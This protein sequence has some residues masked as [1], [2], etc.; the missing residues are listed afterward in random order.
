[1]KQIDITLLF[2]DNGSPVPKTLRGYPTDTPG[3]VVH[4]DYYFDD[5]LDNPP[6]MARMDWTVSNTSGYRA[7]TYFPRLKDALAFARECGN[8]DIDWHNAHSISKVPDDKINLFTNLLR[9]WRKR[10]GIIA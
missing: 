7:A 6:R 4:R 2:T 5:G 10:V 9:K 1:M 8:L 3:L